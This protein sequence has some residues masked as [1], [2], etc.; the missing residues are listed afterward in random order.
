M[1]SK[2]PFRLIVKS[3]LAFSCS[4]IK[5]D[6]NVHKDNFENGNLSLF[7]C[8]FVAENAIK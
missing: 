4:V 6:N 2:T 3:S 5:A 8:P 7:K 1:R